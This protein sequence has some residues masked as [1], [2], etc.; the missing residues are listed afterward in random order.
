MVWLWWC[1]FNNYWSFSS[2]LFYHWILPPLHPLYLHSTPLYPLPLVSMVGWGIISNGVVV[3]MPFYNYVLLSEFY[4]DPNLSLT[5]NSIQHQTTTWHL[6]SSMLWLW[7]EISKKSVSVSGSRG[8][9]IFAKCD[10]MDDEV[11][12]GNKKPTS[13]KVG[14]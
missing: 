11:K 6:A 12:M 4:L 9:T 10:R 5:T 2:S 7:V 14:L 1:P 13:M 3:M 8:L